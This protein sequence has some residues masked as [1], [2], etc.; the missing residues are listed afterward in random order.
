MQVV[1][2]AKTNL[3]GQGVVDQASAA[4]WRKDNCL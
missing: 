2:S 3:A 1:L 4:A